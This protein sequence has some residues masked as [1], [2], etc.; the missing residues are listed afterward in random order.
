M[1]EADRMDIISLLLQVS[2]SDVNATRKITRLMYNA[3]LNHPQLK[4]YWTALTEEGL[5]AYDD[6]TQ[7]FKTTEKGLRFLEVFSKLD[8]LSRQEQQQREKKSN[9]SQNV[10]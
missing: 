10:R 7:S 4:E 9:S 2:L 3:L 5:L 6:A 1:K 8:R